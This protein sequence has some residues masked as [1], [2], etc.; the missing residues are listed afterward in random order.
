VPLSALSLPDFRPMDGKR[1]NNTHER[2]RNRGE[3]VHPSALADHGLLACRTAAKTFLSFEIPP[4]QAVKA[5]P[6]TGFGGGSGVLATQ[7]TLLNL[8]SV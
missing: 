7:N 1:K 5:R 6:R 4:W 2:E 8:V 3:T